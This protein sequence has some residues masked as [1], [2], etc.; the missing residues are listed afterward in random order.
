MDNLQSHP[1]IARRAPSRKALCRPNV[2]D[3][4]WLILPSSIPYDFTFRTGYVRSSPSQPCATLPSTRY[5]RCC[6]RTLQRWSSRHHPTAV[7][8]SR[9]TCATTPHLDERGGRFDRLLRAEPVHGPS[10]AAVFDGLARGALFQYQN[11][12]HGGLGPTQ[13]HWLSVLKETISV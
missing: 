9:G 1:K 10:S 5:H 6:P 3:Q 8:G 4:G 11:S 12:R 2:Q 7:P 13:F